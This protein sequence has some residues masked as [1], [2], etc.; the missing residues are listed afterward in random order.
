MPESTKAIKGFWGHINKTQEHHEESLSLAK[1]GL[2]Q[3]SI[4]I[5]CNGL[6]HIELQTHELT[7][8]F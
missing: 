1:D 6:K 4:I 7:T 5:M 3:T 2:L 8:I